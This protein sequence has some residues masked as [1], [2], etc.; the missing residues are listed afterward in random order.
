M[1]E[2][3]TLILG[4]AGEISFLGDATVPLGVVLSV[5]AE[6]ISAL[7]SASPTAASTFQTT[8]AGVE[9]QFAQMVTEADKAMLVQSQQV[10][11]DAALLGLV[12]EQRSR[13]TWALDTIGIKSAANPGFAT[14]VYRALMPTGHDRYHIRDCRDGLTGRYDQCVGPSAGNGVIGGGTQ[15][16]ITLGPQYQS[17]SS[18]LCGEYSKGEIVNGVPVVTDNYSICEF[19]PRPPTSGTGSGD[20]RRKRASTSRAR[21]I[22]RGPSG[23][24]P[25]WTSTHRS[26]TTPGPSTATSG[27]STRTLRRRTASRTRGSSGPAAKVADAV[28]DGRRR[29]LPDQKYEFDPKV[30]APALLD[31]L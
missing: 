13:G 21:R 24:R 16:F 7:P 25:E 19:D 22:P 9:D 30:L 2:L 28:S 29:T 1:Q 15:N 12:G 6:L 26:G 8:Y 3:F 23:A 14:W 17:G 31:F 11:Q 4:I 18:F 10:R 20:H 27:T 5:T